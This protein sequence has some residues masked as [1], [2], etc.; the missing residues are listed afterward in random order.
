M[1]I[2]PKNL[3]WA[4]AHPWRALRYL[5][6][7]DRIPYQAIARFIPSVPV[8]I[9]A[10]AADG[11]NTIE[12]A[13]FWPGAVIHAFEPVPDAMRLNEEVTKPIR[14]RVKLYPCALGSVPARLQMNVSGNGGSDGTQSSSLLNPSGHLHEFDN[15]PFNRKIEVD[16]V[17]LDD[18]AEREGV[19]KLDF[20]WLDLQGY[21]LEALK[22]AERLLS[23]VS[24]VH[25]EV[26]HRQLYEGGV[27][28]PELKLWL[29]QRGFTPV[30]NATFRLGGN[31]LFSR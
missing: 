27:L 8:I 17:R 9:E 22:G 10:G 15:V 6:H 25:V 18:W 14:D 23:K 16:V 20:L 2:T 4:T 30:I 7:H 13:N 29:Q 26:S 3:I 28:Y 21:E 5:K 24:A 19:E 31:V 11:K 1:K 12:M